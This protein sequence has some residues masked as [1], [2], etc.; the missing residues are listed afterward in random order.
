MEFGSIGSFSSF[1]FSFFGG[2]DV[3]LWGSCLVSLSWV[4]G[5]IGSVGGLPGLGSSI[6]RGV[7]GC[8]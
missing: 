4:G 7:V 2:C 6:G 1:S 5:Y 3:E 8:I